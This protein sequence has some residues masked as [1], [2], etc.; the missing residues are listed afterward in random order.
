MRSCRSVVLPPGAVEELIVGNVHVGIADRL[1]ANLY[2]TGGGQLGNIRYRDRGVR[3][4]NVARQRDG[5][6]I[7]IPGL[8]VK[9]VLNWSALGQLIGDRGVSRL[10]NVADVDVYLVRGGVV[11]PDHRIEELNRIY[12]NRIN[13]LAGNQWNGTLLNGPKVDSPVGPLNSQK[14]QRSTGGSELVT[15]T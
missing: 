7:F 6:G 14:I 5:R 8:P 10:S 2:K 9:P 1:I 15:S 12:G 3:G 11:L 13:S 4:R